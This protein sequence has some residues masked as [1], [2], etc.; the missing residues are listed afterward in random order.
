[1]DGRGTSLSQFNNENTISVQ[2]DFVL[3]FPGRENLSCV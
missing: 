2:E 1:M 3:Q